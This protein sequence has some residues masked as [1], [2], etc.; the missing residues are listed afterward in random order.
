[1]SVGPVEFLG[2]T[3]LGYVLKADKTKDF[4]V[5]FGAL[6]V[7]AFEE[8]PVEVELSVGERAYVVTDEANYLFAARRSRRLREPGRDKGRRLC[9]AGEESPRA[10]ADPVQ[11]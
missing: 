1:M 3:A 6:D 4:S 2:D 11:G 10:A 9:R 8:I 7:S 5:T